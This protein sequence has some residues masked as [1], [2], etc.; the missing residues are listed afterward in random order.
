M[1]VLSLQLLAQ[2]ENEEANK[3]SLTLSIGH[4]HIGQGIQNGQRKTLALP[5]WGLNYDRL[6]NEKWTIGLHTDIIVEEFEVEIKEGDVD[7]TIERSRPFSSAI[8]VTHRVND[9]LAASIGFGREFAPQEDFNL[10]RIGLEPY[11][12]LPN[13]FEIVGTLSVDFRFEAYNAF[14]IALG[15][16]K[17]F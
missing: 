7:V 1:L 4:V 8:T 15:I 14:N 5:S 16:A 10:I 12:E 3:N 9:F 11:F 17:K 6:L 2:E 13:D